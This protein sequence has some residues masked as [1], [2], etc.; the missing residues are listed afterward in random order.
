MTNDEKLLREGFELA[1]DSAELCDEAEC[2][3]DRAGSHINWTSARKALEERLSGD[4]DDDYSWE[5]E[6]AHL[7]IDSEVE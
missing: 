5:R 2:N 4:D 7:L 3:H 1:V 6:P